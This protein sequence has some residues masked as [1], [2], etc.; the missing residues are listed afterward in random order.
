MRRDDEEGT[1]IPETGAVDAPRV[2][3]GVEDGDS[4]V[5]RSLCVGV[6]QNP[7]V[8][9]VDG[10][11]CFD[12]FAKK[13]SCSGLSVQ[14]RSKNRVPVSGSE[15]FASRFSL[16]ELFRGRCNCASLFVQP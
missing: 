1:C 2:V 13:N 16:G 4:S 5:R 10:L 11:L 9:S 6:S 8:F 15:K 12:C 7:A 14:R 3:C